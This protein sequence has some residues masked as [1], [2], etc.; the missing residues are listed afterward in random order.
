MYKKGSAALREIPLDCKAS[1]LLQS[2]L[3]E[4]NAFGLFTIDPAGLV[5]IDS[6][7]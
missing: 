6:N 7:I 2:V 1:F 3:P 4:I 5:L